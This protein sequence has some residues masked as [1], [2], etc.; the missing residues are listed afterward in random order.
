VK[1]GLES[2]NKTIAAAVLG[3][4]ALMLVG[5][6]LFFS[7]SPEF[8]AAPPT[9]AVE[10][11]HPALKITGKRKP[12]TGKKAKEPARDNL[13]PTLRLDLLASIEQIKYEGSGRNIFMSQPDPEIPKPVA[14]GASDQGK[15]NQPYVPPAPPPPPPINLK[16]IGFA[17]EP[18]EVKKIFLSQG[19]DVFIAREGEIVDRRYKVLRISPNAVEVEDVIN[20]HSQQIPLT[21]G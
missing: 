6:A 8:A 18:G 14:S 20:S 10:Q 12:A 2:R 13:D 7:P 9:A 17:S 11:A 19:E 1:L 5:R 16:F 3:G 21:Q 4:L 15:E